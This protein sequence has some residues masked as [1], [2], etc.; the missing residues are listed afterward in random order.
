[1]TN[2]AASEAFELGV[3]A[4]WDAANFGEAYGYTEAIEAEA[5]R[6]AGDRFP[7]EPEQATEWANGFI[8]GSE[9]YKRGEWQDG[10]SKDHEEG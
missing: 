8:V 5:A 1:M 9:R 6:R 3:S 7:T 4:G 10:S 2:P